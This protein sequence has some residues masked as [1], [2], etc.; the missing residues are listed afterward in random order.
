MSNFCLT[1]YFN[2][3][4]GMY[5]RCGKCENC[6]KTK[7]NDWAYRMDRELKFNPNTVYSAFVT[8]TY[9]DD[10]LHYFDNPQIHRKYNYKDRSQYAVIFP[11]DWSYFLSHLQK[12][13]K[14][15]CGKLQ[16]YYTLMEYGSVEKRPHIHIILFS[17][18][19]EQST[20]SFIR[21]CWD[22]ISKDAIIDYQPI[23]FA[24]ITYCAKHNL[25]ECGGNKFQ[26]Y[27]C[28]PRTSCSKKNGGIGIDFFMQNLGKMDKYAIVNNFKISTPEFYRKKQKAYQNLQE[29]DSDIKKMILS[30]AILLQRVLSQPCMQK[31]ESTQRNVIRKVQQ[32]KRDAIC[33]EYKKHYLFRD[34]KYDFVDYESD[35]LPI[36]REEN[37]RLRIARL[38]KLYTRTQLK[39]KHLTFIKTL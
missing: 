1:P 33:R 31:F 22:K 29:F 4:L 9:K 8:L 17:P 7:R 18:I 28:P 2:K 34:S 19:D 25:K 26:N 14:A 21:L 23:T 3:E 24:D 35:I 6:L 13:T 37:R 10:D 39:I 5:C 27:I 11:Y 20:Q 36:M 30:D 38:N 15:A 32:F 12:L 16:R